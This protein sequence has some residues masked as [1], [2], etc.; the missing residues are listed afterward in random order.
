MSEHREQN[1]HGHCEHALDGDGVPVGPLELN[2]PVGDLIKTAVDNHTL[3]IGNAIEF[4]GIVETSHG[5]YTVHI[6][7]CIAPQP[8]GPA[9]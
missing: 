4:N 2:T 1:T 5:P 7:V 9:N 8:R 6:H 3:R